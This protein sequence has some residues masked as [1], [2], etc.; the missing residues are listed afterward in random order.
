MVPYFISISHVPKTRKGNIIHRIYRRF[1]K[2]YFFIAILPYMHGCN[3]KHKAKTAHNAIKDIDNTAKKKV[4]KQPY[5]KTAQKHKDEHKKV[6]NRYINLQVKKGDKYINEHKYGLAR[7]AYLT[8]YFISP[9]AGKNVLNRLRSM[10]DT[11]NNKKATL[12]KPKRKVY[13]ILDIRDFL[14]I[15]HPPKNFEELITEGKSLQKQGELDRAQGKYLAAFQ[16]VSSEKLKKRSMELIKDI[17]LSKLR[18]RAA[19]V[20]AE[21]IDAYHA[22]NYK[23]A[24]ENIEKAFKLDPNNVENAVMQR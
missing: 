6:I 21:A 19:V 18:R 1:I 14:K 9:K 24:R 3:I 10:S 12:K 23:E 13:K 20:R 17:D 5:E 4:T 11:L 8:S 2:I 22:A 15:K 16:M 7:K